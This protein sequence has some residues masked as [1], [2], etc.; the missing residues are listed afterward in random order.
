MKSI[1]ER[2]YRKRVMKVAKSQVNL[3]YLFV[4]QE[5]EPAWDEGITFLTVVF[6]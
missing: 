6:S 1:I 5:Q 4:T 3:S 2:G